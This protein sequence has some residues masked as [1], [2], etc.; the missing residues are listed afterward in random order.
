[1]TN[2]YYNYIKT[3][4]VFRLTNGGYFLENEEHLAKQYIEENGG[5]YY[6]DVIHF[7]A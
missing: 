5:D 7:F 6:E 4:K 1:M 2:N 3:M